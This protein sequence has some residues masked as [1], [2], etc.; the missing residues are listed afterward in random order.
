M[1]RYWFWHNLKYDIKIILKDKLKKVYWKVLSKKLSYQDISISEIIRHEIKYSL[2]FHYC[3]F[4]VKLNLIYFWYWEVHQSL[5][6]KKWKIWDISERTILLNIF[7]WF[8]KMKFDR[9]YVN[10]IISISKIW[11]SKFEL[12]RSSNNEKK[13]KYFE[14]IIRN[15]ISLLFTSKYFII[16]QMYFFRVC[17]NH[18]WK[19]ISIIFIN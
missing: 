7:H 16:L 18:I 14:L 9:R 8:G 2:F 1:S 3:M 6:I 17:K 4:F 10:K 5:Q 15:Q 19:Y 13:S 11:I 12:C